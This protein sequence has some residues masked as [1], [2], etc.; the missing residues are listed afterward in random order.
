MEMERLILCLHYAAKPYWYSMARHGTAK[1]TCV[2][3]ALSH[4]TVLYRSQRVRLKQQIWC[5]TLRYGT[6][7]YSRVNIVGRMRFLCKLCARVITCT[8]SRIVLMTH[9]CVCQ[10]TYR[11]TLALRRVTNYGPVDRRRNAEVNRDME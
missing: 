10:R 4:H 6:S 9:T 8:S 5:G 2:N 7:K 1:E 3:S 11:F